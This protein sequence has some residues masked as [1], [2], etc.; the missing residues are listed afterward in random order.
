M[1]SIIN[2]LKHPLLKDVN[3]ND[4]KRIEIHRKIFLNKKMLLAVFNNFHRTFLFLE[5]KF[6]FGDGLRIELGAGI[7]PIKKTLKNVLA[8]DILPGPDID[9]ILDAERLELNSNSV[10]TLFIQNSF[11]HFSNPGSF[12]KELDR[13]LVKGGGSIILDPYYG[14]L[15]CK[16]YPKIFN[17]EIFDKNTNKW[18]YENLGPMKGANQALS[19]VIFIKDRDKFKELYPSLEI[20]DQTIC[21]NY[22]LYLFSGG[23][24][25]KQIV[26]NIFIPLILLIELIIYPFRKL[27]AL[28]HIIVIRKK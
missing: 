10:K 26:P 25:F 5:K 21:S 13:V 6:I 28:H 2:F 7:Y 19:Y 23:L 14:W 1:K 22:F 9:L 17:T 4:A 27:F 15:A 20:V 11:H 8:S 24:N 18:N 16:I 3:I 12:F